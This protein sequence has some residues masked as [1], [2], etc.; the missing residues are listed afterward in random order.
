MHPYVH[1]SLCSTMLNNVEHSNSVQQFITPKETTLHVHQPQ[2][3]KGNVVCVCVCVA[4]L[5]AQ[6][7]KS[8]PAMQETWV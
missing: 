3:N 4:S 1:S 2:M 8:L 7:V 5:V 6:M